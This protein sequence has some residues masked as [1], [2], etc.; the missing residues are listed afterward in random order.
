MVWV[1]YEVDL[2]IRSFGHSTGHGFHVSNKYFNF[3]EK[4]HVAVCS[5]SCQDFTLKIFSSYFL[6]NTDIDRWLYDEIYCQVWCLVSAYKLSQNYSEWC[7]TVLTCLMISSSVPCRISSRYSFLIVL[8]VLLR[9]MRFPTQRQTWSC[10]FLICHVDVPE[11]WPSS[12]THSTYR[13][14]NESET[15]VISWWRQWVVSLGAGSRKWGEGGE[16]AASVQSVTGRRQ[17]GRRGQSDRR[18]GGEAKVTEWREGRW[19]AWSYHEGSTTFMGLVDREREG[20]ELSASTVREAR[21][22]W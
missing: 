17:R 13:V 6:F 7:G 8:D 9:I 21:L 12:H 1:G 14:T 5:L 18:E 16:L 15:E 20:E 19:E 2:S 22:V 10:V 4:V 11:Y 3:W